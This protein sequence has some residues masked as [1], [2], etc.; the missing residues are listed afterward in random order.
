MSL[1]S[2]LASRWLPGGLR[3]KGLL[4]SHLQFVAEQMDGLQKKL[5]EEAEQLMAEI[6]RRV[7]LKDAEQMRAEVGLGS[8]FADAV[9]AWRIGSVAMGV[10]LRIT[11]PDANTAVFEHRVCPTWKFFSER[12]Q[13]ACEWAC[14]PAAEALAT[15]ICPEVKMV[16]NRKA[17]LETP[18]IKS[19][20]WS[21]DN[22]THPK[23]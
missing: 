10:K 6:V 3:S 17:M 7:A 22:E 16:V 18:C 21:G 20:V 14:L 1:K 9:A 2:F 15:A 23:E 19:L 11:R 13:L 12:N 5:P 8:S 4:Q